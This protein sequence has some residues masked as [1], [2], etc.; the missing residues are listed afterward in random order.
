M[1]AHKQFFECVELVSM[2]DP[3]WMAHTTHLNG[4]ATNSIE[5]PYNWTDKQMS[6]QKNKS[7]NIKS[8]QNFIR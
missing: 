2:C 6:G 7:N 8:Y 3:A 5:Q 4:T 1:N